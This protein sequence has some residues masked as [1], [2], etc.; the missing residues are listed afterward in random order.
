M[1]TEGIQMFKYFFEVHNTSNKVLQQYNAVDDS[2]D[3]V[4]LVA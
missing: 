2:D 1:N 4:M 3:S